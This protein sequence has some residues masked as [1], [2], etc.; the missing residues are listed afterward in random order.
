MIATLTAGWKWKI[1]KDT[2]GQ[3][4]TEYA[5]MAGFLCAACAAALP[6]IAISIVTVLSKVAAML[7]TTGID[8]APGG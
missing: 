7:T 8:T 6:D 4:F 3:D 5:L 2:R 1:W